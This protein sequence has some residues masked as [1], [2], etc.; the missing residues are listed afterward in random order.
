MHVLFKRIRNLHTPI[1]LQLFLFDHVIL[2]AALYV[3]EIWRFESSL[4]IENPPEASPET[5]I[6]AVPYSH[7]F[8]S[9]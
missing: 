2:T 9:M 8:L 3:C 7:I 6:V 1:D 5:S 4:I